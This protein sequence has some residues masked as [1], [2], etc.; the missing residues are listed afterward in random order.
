MT[1]RIFLSGLDLSFL[2]KDKPAH[3][4]VPKPKRGKRA[5]RSK[6]GRRP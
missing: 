1:T 4:S 2:T 3:T 6:K 5:S